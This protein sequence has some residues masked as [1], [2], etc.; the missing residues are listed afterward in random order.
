[1]LRTGC[2]LPHFRGGEGKIKGVALITALLVVALASIAAAAMLSSAELAIQRTSMVQDSE[3]ANWVADG[4]ESWVKGILEKDRKDGAVD[5]LGEDWAR[6]VDVLPVDYGTARGSVIDAQSRFNLNNLSVSAPDK[7]VKQFA[8]LVTALGIQ[9]GDLPPGLPAL[10]RDWADADSEPSLPFGAEDS[11]YLGLKIP[12]RTAN[13]AFAS[14][15][16]LR[17]IQGITPKLY[18]ALAPYLSAL[19]DITTV[20]VNTADEAV[21]RSL[22]PVVD[23]AKLAAFIKNRKDAPAEDVQKLKTDGTFGEGFDATLASV[24][25]HNFQLRAEVFVGSSRVSLYSSIYRPDQ[26]SPVVLT[27]SSDDN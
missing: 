4:I 13:R 20:N 12:Y 19:P 11:Y 18:K 2:P 1:M 16:E 24:N 25:S 27:H 22:S 6:S 10:I 8:R 5:S 7:Y 14:V 26:G 15:S 3:R 23:E 9:T 21:L 17:A